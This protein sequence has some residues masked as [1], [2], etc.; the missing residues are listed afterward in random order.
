MVQ[1]PIRLQWMERNI[2]IEKRLYTKI[3]SFIETL[4]EACVVGAHS[5]EDHIVTKL[6]HYWTTACLQHKERKMFADL[7]FQ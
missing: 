3:Y 7:L 6:C 1:L 4:Q 5:Q 2:E